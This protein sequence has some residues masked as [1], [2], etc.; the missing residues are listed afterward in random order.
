[1]RHVS[2]KPLHAAL[3]LAAATSACEKRD[4]V[5]DETQ[6][7]TATTPPPVRAESV[8]VPSATALEVY[9]EMD[10]AH[11]G[12]V[13]RDFDR[14]VAALQSA[15][16]KVRNAAENAPADARTALQAAA[17]DLE[18]TAA[19]VRA[20]SI[21]SINLFDRKLA[22]VHASLSRVHHAKAVEAWAA[23]DSSTAGR[24]LRLAADQLS[25]GLRRVGRNVKKTTSAAVTDA[26]RLGEKL[27][28]RV[29]AGGADVERTMQGLGREIERLAGD[30]VTTPR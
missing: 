30:L 14:T 19:D 28:Q 22:A 1:M 26:Q 7:A 15:G 21:S 24:E 11:E 8:A 17:D 5:R 20:G 9:V 27:A 10:Q 6:A 18:K 25:H 23:K 4:V 12:F 13:R 16:R 3:L 2:L 29:D